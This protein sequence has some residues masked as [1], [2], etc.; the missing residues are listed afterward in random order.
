MTLY[1]DVHRNQNDV[2]KEALAQAHLSD[3]EAQDKHGV[4]YL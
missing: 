3:L 1:L 2:T 4:S